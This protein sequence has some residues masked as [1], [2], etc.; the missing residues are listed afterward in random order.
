MWLRKVSPQIYFTHGTLSKHF[1][2]KK[3][4]RSNLGL[5]VSNFFTLY[6][7]KVTI[8]SPT[9]V[10]PKWGTELLPA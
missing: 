6:T 4:Q 5:K 9:E 2:A 1:S 3:A 10:R 7:V 8:Q